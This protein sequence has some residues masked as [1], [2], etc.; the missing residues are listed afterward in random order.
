MGEHEVKAESGKRKAEMRRAVFLD[1]D[2]VINR[3]LERDAK[4]YPPT[5]LAEFEILPEVPEALARLKAAGYLLVVATNQPD[6]GRGTL[7]RGIVEQL[8]AHLAARLPVDRVEV[9]FHPGQGLSDCDC[10]KPKPGMLRRAAGELGIDLAR[11]WMVGDRWR[12]VDCGHAA[13][14]RTVF[15]DR[16]YAEE[17]RQKPDFSARHLGEAADIILNQPNN[18]FMKRTLKD[19]SV[20]IFADGADKAGMLKL[21]ADPLIQGLTTNPTLMRKA[22]LTDFEAFA[23]DILQ[24]ITVKP[25]SLEVFSDEFPEMKRQALKINGWGKN[26][27]V[28]IPITNT[29]NESSLALIRELANEGVKLNVTA[30]LTLEQVRG[31]A[32]ALNPQA[33]AVVSVFAGRIADTGVDPVEI[34]A[35][36]KAILQGLPQAEL[37]WASVREVLNIFQ[38]ND[39][40]SHIVTVPHDILGKAMKMSGMDLGELSLDT[41]KMF[42]TDAKAAG[43]TL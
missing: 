19:L 4:P 31:V 13:G 25:L 39:C 16:G 1:R 28:K 15:I 12:D 33:P 24:T 8:H 29:R 38:A 30:I 27:Y 17:L 32:A 6:V 10:R 43:F 23:R 41:V 26:V 42:A 36:S 21:N 40:G 37:L 34:M 9:C 11:S 2:G 35:E 22:G 20:K 3:A 5:S 14:C 7:D 18:H